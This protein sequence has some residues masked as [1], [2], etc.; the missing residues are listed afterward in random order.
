[1]AGKDNAMLR[2]ENF[3]RGL[4]RGDCDQLFGAVLLTAP[5]GQ[6]ASQWALRFLLALVES[7]REVDSVEMTAPSKCPLTT[8]SGHRREASFVAVLWFELRVRKM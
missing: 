2:H 5:I 7:R 6:S 4:Q 1:M 3:A 8:Q